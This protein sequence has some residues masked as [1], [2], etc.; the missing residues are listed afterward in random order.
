MSTRKLTGGLLTLATLCLACVLATPALAAEQ[1]GFSK[2]FGSAGT[3]T[4]Q[5]SDPTGVALGANGD[6]YV[7]DKGNKR[8]ERFNAGGVYL[9]QFNGSGEYEV[10][11]TKET[12]AAA[13]TGA[14][15]EPAG[16]AVDDSTSSVDPSK[17]D[18]YV[19]DA[20]N[21]AVYKFSATGEYLGQIT[22]AEAGS[23][24][25]TVEGVAVSPAGELYVYAN[26][27]YVDRFSDALVNEYGSQFEGESA[28]LDIAVDGEGNVY[29]VR[30]YHHKVAR[31]HENEFGG[32]LDL[33]ACECS[34]GVGVDP[35]NNHV[36]VTQ[37][38]SV[39]EYGPFEEPASK[40]LAT[41]GSASAQEGELQ[42][43]DGIAISTGQEI[44][45]VD[46][47]ADR[48]DVFS[49]VVVPDVIEEEATGVTSFTAT[50]AGKVDADGTSGAS[51]YFEYGT[52]TAYG[53]SSPA[54]PGTAFS[55]TSPVPATTSLSGLAPETI[56][57]YR[58]DATNSSG[59]V[60]Y[61]KDETFTTSAAIAPT[62]NDRAPAASEVLASSARL[63][64][65]VN[66]E[67]SQTFYHFEYGPTTAYGSSTPT[68]DAGDGY[69][70][71]L[72]SQ[73]LA[74]L[75]PGT[76]YHYALVASDPAGT[77]IGPDETF[78]TAA[79]TPPL[80]STGAASS[81]SSTSETLTGTVEPRGLP[82]SYQFEIGT[83]TSYGGLLAGAVETLTGSEGV[84][85]T[86]Q[87]LPLGTAFHYRL[88]ASNADG[89]T[90][91]P[92]ETFTTPGY[93]NPLVVPA[94]QPLIAGS[95][96]VS[97]PKT[98]TTVAKTLTRAQKLTA[99]LKACHKDH[100]RAKQSKCETRARKRYAPTRG[101]KK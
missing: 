10:E 74:G 17:G 87:G 40:L 58:L 66:P 64:G 18:V 44:Y 51:Y 84:S 9:G 65:T 98:T 26:G 5:F 90:Y 70:D 52:S 91:G 73:L 62:V 27:E 59:H 3:G 47:K 7:V 96:N 43:T 100:G 68:A 50:L 83:S 31:L 37:G 92:D 61:G 46:S 45:V 6:V 39:A 93:V 22:E 88:V 89:T 99:A 28:T 41:F 1:I 15:A 72:F 23:P 79:A 34:E 49:G 12:G 21:L 101:K 20:G 57:H 42:E 25:A 67:H 77:V 29:Q 38:T 19:A 16:I 30:E 85:V 2:S 36:Y 94:A 86:F 69:G 13:P 32:Y 60:S 71:E 48:V 11:G 76:T 33:D 8:V 75:A 82:T 56:Y 80:L 35:T 24:F 95:I 53:A 78:T 54:Q 97:P 55:G 4:A 63:T 14:F 81:P